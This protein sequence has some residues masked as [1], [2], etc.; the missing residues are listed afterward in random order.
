M[1][2]KYCGR[3]SCNNIMCDTYIDS[4]GY[5]C[6]ECKSEFKE[7]VKKNN[8]NLTKEGEINRELVK[9]K[10]APKGV[11]TDGREISIDD[12]FNEHTD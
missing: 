10:M 7:Y 2:V 1:G 8:L 12:F 9:F 4:F 11:F 6:D 5:I 3:L